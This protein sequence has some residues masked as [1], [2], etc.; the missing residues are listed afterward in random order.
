[1]EDLYAETLRKLLNKDRDAKYAYLCGLVSGL[2]TQA[3][4]LKSGQI[5]SDQMPLFYLKEGAG[6]TE[7]EAIEAL[8]L[9]IQKYIKPEMLMGWREWQDHYTIY[10]AALGR[11]SQFVASTYQYFVT[12]GAS[13][14]DAVALAINMEKRRCSE[15]VGLVWND[16]DE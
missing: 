2:R 16:P 12:G 13:K 15:I 9:W 4:L 6:K 11:G 14:E 8:P 7:L 3:A 10:F 5:Y 1:M